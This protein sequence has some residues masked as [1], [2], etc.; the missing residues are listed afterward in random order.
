MVVILIYDDNTFVDI[1]IDDVGGCCGDVSVMMS[2]VKVKIFWTVVLEVM[3]WCWLSCDC[4]DVYEENI[5]VVLV[6]LVV[7]IWLC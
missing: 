2:V 4:G 5:L 7:V 3:Q 6:I 1:M